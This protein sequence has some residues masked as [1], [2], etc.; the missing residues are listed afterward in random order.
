MPI[1]GG[2][3]HLKGTLKLFKGVVENFKDRNT[4]QLFECFSCLLDIYLSYSDAL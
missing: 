1:V 4:C 3:Y 2:A